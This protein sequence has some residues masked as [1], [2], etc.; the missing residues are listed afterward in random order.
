MLVTTYENTFFPIELYKLGIV[1]LVAS[2][3]INSFKIKVTLI[4][5]G[6][7]KK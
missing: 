3:Y 1:Y 5:V 4:S 6:L 7:V 2:S